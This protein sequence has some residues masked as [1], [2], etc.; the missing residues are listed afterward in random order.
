MQNN[1]STENLSLHK[2]NGINRKVGNIANTNQIY[3]SDLEWGWIAA[4]G[5]VCLK[6]SLKNSNNCEL[7]GQ[8]SVQLKILDEQNNFWQF[9][10][11]LVL[12]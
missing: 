10:S 12:S 4:F 5:G 9:P 7:S 8:T 1:A 2:E 11:H 6:S 3:A